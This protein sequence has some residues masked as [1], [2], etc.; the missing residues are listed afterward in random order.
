MYKKNLASLNKYVMIAFANE[1]MILPAQSA[2]IF[3]L[4][5]FLVVRLS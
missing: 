1:T 3:V 4:C 2:V 5:L